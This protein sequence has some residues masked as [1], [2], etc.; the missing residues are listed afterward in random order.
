MATTNKIALVTGGSRGLGKNMALSLANKGIDV[1][2]T[3]LSKKDEAEAAVK[4]IEQ[5]GRKA[6]ALPLDSGDIQR[7]D[8]FVKEFS[9][10]LKDHFNADRFDFLINNAGIGHYALFENNTEEAFDRIMNINLKGVFFLTQKLLPLINDGGRIINLSSGLARFTIPGNSVYAAMKGAIETLTRY[11]AVELG[12]RRIAVNTLAP[13]AI[14]TDFNGGAVRDNPQYNKMVAD[15]TA[16]GRVGLPD[17]I[18]G[19]AAFLCTDEA[20][21]INAQRLEVSGGQKI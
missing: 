9:A 4:T 13:G 3:Y 12:P 14:E 2:L 19:V 17:D 8:P 11:L 10:V 18:G 1:V 7:F 5:S 15:S 20:R 16:L 21:W 6:W